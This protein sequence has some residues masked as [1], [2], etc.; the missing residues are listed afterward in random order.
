MTTDIRAKVYCSLGKVISGDF[1]DDY[2]QD[3]GLIKT[4]GTVILDGIYR[5]VIGDKVE[6]AYYR[7]GLVS[8]L[9]RTLRVL[10]S[11]ADP[12]R[13]ITTVEI[14]CKFTYFDNR[15][16]PIVNPKSIEE[17]NVDCEIFRTAIIPISAAY[18]F[19]KCLDELG[20]QSDPI[21]LTNKFSVEEFDLSSGYIQVMSELLS[22]EGY[23]CYLDGSETVKIRSFNETT[24]TGPLLTSDDL[25]DL[26][27]I[28]VGELSGDSIVVRFNSLTLKKPEELDQQQ[29]AKNNWEYSSSVNIGGKIIIYS[30]G[31]ILRSYSAF[32]EVNS[33]RVTGAEA[34]KN[35]FDDYTITENFTYYD[36]W[37]RV[38]RRETIVKRPFVA[39]NPSYV[40][41]LLDYKFLYS[42]IFN[43]STIGIRIFDTSP[44][45]RPFPEPGFFVSTY[46]PLLV[47]GAEVPV[48]EKTVEYYYYQYNPKPSDTACDVP[49]TQSLEYDSLVR[50]EVLKYE[51]AAKIYGV[52]WT[53]G[54]FKFLGSGSIVDWVK[55]NIASLLNPAKTAD[56]LTEKTIEYYEKQPSDMISVSQELLQSAFSKKSGI[57]NNVMTRQITEKYIAFFYTQEGQKYITNATAASWY[58]YN[59]A[60]AFDTAIAIKDLTFLSSDIEQFVGRHAGIEARPPRS[61]LS[62]INNSKSDITESVAEIEWITGSTESSTV[63]EFQLPYAPDD[64]ITYSASS[65]YGLIKSDAKAKAQNYGRIQNALLIGNRNGLSIQISADLMP[66]RPF[67]PIY[68]EEQGLKGQYRINGTSYTF[69]SN[70]IVA[71]TDAMFWGGIA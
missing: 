41:Q 38:I 70:G 8:K 48:E 51:S 12:F 68:I 21:P 63:I 55:G 58:T 11:F 16:P 25:I 34:Q 57:F 40:Q 43:E 1:S 30:W 49:S 71:S 33:Y 46:Y 47:G 22:S 67:D 53:N 54:Y 27:P 19:Q 37:D 13:R 3:N 6:F 32:G 39:V 66:P 61:T 28:G 62:N 15:K 31:S 17:N 5:P 2:L 23:F 65:G 64:E 18:V 56:Y 14:G 59:A 45:R 44:T 26:A 60:Y 10:S 24:N 7:N 29:I 20:L 35:E 50:K 4:S 69:D 52:V 36:A 42:D 9:P